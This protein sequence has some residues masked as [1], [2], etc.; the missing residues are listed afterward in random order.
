[1][2]SKY[3][4]KVISQI[5]RKFPQH[6]DFADL[7]ADEVPQWW[8]KLRPLFETECIRFH[9]LL[10]GS[11]FTFGETATRSLYQDNGNKNSGKLVINDY[12]S[13]INLYS[14]LRRLM[15][16]ASLDCNRGGKLQQRCWLAILYQAVGR[17]GEI[18][19]Q[20]FT[21][22]MWHPTYEALD[23]GWTEL[24]LLEKYAMPMVPHRNHF[25]N[26][27][28]HCLASFWAVERGL[29][30]SDGDE[31]AIA[32]FLFPDLHSLNGSG[33][34][35]KVTA[36][37]RENLPEGCP[38][39]IVSSLSAKS[40]R[41]GS[42]T[43]LCTH[44]SIRGL[45]ACG[46]SGHAT[47]TS[48]DSYLDKT[49]IARG[50]CDGKALGGFMD[51][52]AD[53]KVPRLECLGV[54]TEVAIQELMKQLF[55]VS[56]P[57]FLPRGSLHVVLRTCTASL[58]MY[59]RMVTQE[60]RSAN[61]VATKLRNSARSAL[62]T[63]TCFPNKS[64]ESLLDDWSDIIKTDYQERNPEIARATP[65]AIQMATVMNQQTKL[66]IQMKS[67]MGD[68]QVNYRQ[69]S[70]SQQSAI[71]GLQNDVASLRGELALANSKL[72][73]FKTPDAATRRRLHAAVDQAGGEDG[74]NKRPRIEDSPA[75]AP[76]AQGDIPPH[77]LATDPQQAPA[78]A[79]PPAAA[80]PPRELVYG[81]E[82]RR[83][84]EGNSNKDM[85]ISLVLQDLYRRRLL[86]APVWTDIDPP[87]H[88]YKERSFLKIALE[89]VES[90]IT[91]EE[92]EAFTA[93]GTSAADLEKFSKSIEKRC[94]SQILLYEG[95][96]REVE[97]QTG[98][99]K[100]ATYLAVGRRVRE[101]K[102]VLKPLTGGNQDP[103][104]QERPPAPDPK[105]PPDNRSMI[106]FMVARR[107]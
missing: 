13:A 99:T 65:D 82:A 16:D 52:D 73:V 46:R 28:Y 30:R 22:W 76:T 5:R 11:D 36:V 74:A 15:K 53:I 58:T 79:P 106:S 4:G 59:H 56:V 44:R 8:T 68:M 29:F 80:P 75:A 93:D 19:R 63:D 45:D 39:D 38:A 7:R 62:I 51:V 88:D 41:R 14:I 96:S 18:K 87:R 92:R 1:M 94:M 50:L 72:S 97:T 84:A 105:T 6:P 60:L 102:K 48:I 101:Y 100:K 67:M 31:R 20:D 21:E 90:V 42:I 12:I 71:S 66:M 54:H 85:F 49:F 24:K 43:Q 37:I 83:T 35:K 26:D 95:G 10:L 23:I 104:L 78:R 98:T 2:L 91:A 34:T 107:K 33:V 64:P 69:H 57:S 9:F 70:S 17:G 86:K 61:A 77:Q 32:N 3:I 27:F 25:L 40:T 103:P 55:V 47:G 89:L 81:A